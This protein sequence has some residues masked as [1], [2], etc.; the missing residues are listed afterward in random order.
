MLPYRAS[1]P[2]IRGWILLLLLSAYPRL[3]LAAPAIVLTNVPPFGALADLS[4]LVADAAPGAYRVAVFIFV[5]S[6]GWWSKP[7]CDPQLTVI[8][9]DGSWTAD[10]TTGP[11]DEYATKITALL[12]G[13]NYGEPCVKGPATLPTNVTAQAIASATVERVDPNLRWINFSGYDW[14][15]KT[16]SGLIGPGPN[17]FSDSTN[18]VWLDAQGRLHLRITNRSNDWQ[19][20]EV[21]TRRTFGY[22][23]YRFELDSP[24]D[25]LN[26]SVVLGLFTWSDDP[27]Y[28]H[29]EIDIECGRWANPNDVNNAQYVV[30]P[31]DW[32]GHLVRYAVSA[33]L[34]NSTH[35]FT[36]ETNRVSYQSQRGSYS[37][38]PAP[39]N[40]ISSW[41]F[42]D[43]SAVPQTGDENIRINLWLINGNAPTDN[44][45]VE[46]VIKSF[47][48]VPLAPPLP[49]LLVQPRLQDGR[50]LFDISTQPDRRYQVQVSTNLF[51][52]QDLG[53]LLATNNMVKFA[54]SN[55]VGDGPRFYR[56]ITLP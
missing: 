27:A 30:Q 54:G 13:T 18:N 37:P 35:L 39:T 40:I 46:F 12:V 21:V 14:W 42:T 2:Q 48:F 1:G 45:E 9:P 44:R 25:N 53:T 34:T 38:T 36:W 29:R 52:W 5:P 24:V 50:F 32:P 7:Y 3:G 43:A 20:A 6:A 49:A 16:S 10:I 56:A 11:G 4:G 8:R 55:D 15:V 41:V 23:S 51:F 33:S 22:G 19:C 47:Q 28:T 31:W 17:H 26:P